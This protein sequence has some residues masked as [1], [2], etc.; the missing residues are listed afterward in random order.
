MKTSGY[1]NN[2]QAVKEQKGDIL[3]YY[4][5]DGKIRAQVSTIFIPLLQVVCY[6]KDT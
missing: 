5:K 4:H 2:G 3:T 1:Y 6:S